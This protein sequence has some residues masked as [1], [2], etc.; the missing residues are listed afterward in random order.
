[1]SIEVTL[2]ESEKLVLRSM[3]NLRS[4]RYSGLVELQVLLGGLSCSDAWLRFL[5]EHHFASWFDSGWGTF[6]TFSRPSLTWLGDPPELKEKASDLDEAIYQ[7]AI[8]QQKVEEY[9]LA[10]KAQKTVKELSDAAAKSIGF[11]E[12]LGFLRIDTDPAWVMSSLTK[13]KEPWVKITSEGLEVATKIRENR[14]LVVRQQQVRRNSIFVASAIG[15]TDTDG[16]YEKVFKPTCAEFGLDAVR[17][18]LSEPESTITEAIL[19]G[20]QVAECVIADLTYARPSVYFEAGFGGGLGVPL[21]LTC[22]MDHQ[23]G[24]DD[25]ERVHFDLEQY[26]IS[27]WKLEKGGS[28]IWKKGMDPKSRLKALIGTRQEVTESK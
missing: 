4:I 7:Q 14:L 15:R 16:L 8:H 24:L 13:G 25:S 12:R 17:V 20:I 18:D 10:K 5:L 1:V 21:L 3:A 22:R 2:N 23:K 28:Y 19:Q 9:S 11:M 26:K 6:S 27:F